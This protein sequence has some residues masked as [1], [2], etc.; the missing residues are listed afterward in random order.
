[1]Q[2]DALARLDA[3]YTYRTTDEIAAA[4]DRAIA[5]EREPS[6]TVTVHLTHGDLAAL[7][8]ALAYSC[9]HLGYSP[10]RGRVIRKIDD[11]RAELESDV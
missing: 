3:A 9:K 8:D 7:L 5:R 4:R 11:A 6:E 1:M 2:A 10:L